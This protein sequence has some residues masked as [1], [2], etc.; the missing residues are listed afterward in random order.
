MTHSTS[1]TEQESQ[2]VKGCETF[3]GEQENGCLMK[4]ARNLNLN[5][6]WDAKKAKWT[7]TKLK[8]LKATTSPELV[9][10]TAKGLD[11]VLELSIFVSRELLLRKYNVEKHDSDVYD[12]FQLH[13]L[14][15][16]RF[17]IV[18]E[19]ENLRMRTVRSSQ[20]GRIQSFDQFLQSL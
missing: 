18:T 7:E 20:A 17:V 9:A 19:D 11:A 14:A 10:E 12:Q 4:S 1:L 8:R 6:A 5:Q 3:V 2:W 16:D 13:Y 15:V